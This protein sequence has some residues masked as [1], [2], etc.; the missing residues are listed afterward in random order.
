M[1]ERVVLLNDSIQREVNQRDLLRSGFKY[2]YERTAE[3]DSLRYVAER[4]RTEAKHREQRTWL[5]ALLMIVAVLAP[6]AWLRMRYTTR[7]KRA[8]QEA[9]E[10]LVVSERAREATEVRMR[11]ARD[12]HDQLG[13]DLTKLALLSTEAK[14]IAHA[15]RA[16]VA[17]LVNVAVD[18][19]RVA[20]EA[21]RAIL[22]GPS[23]RTTI[24]SPDLPNAFVPIA[25]ACSSGA[26]WPIPSTAGMKDP[27]RHWTL[28]SNATS[29]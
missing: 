2:A 11:I 5:L 13:S 22:S 24:H 25:H 4:T 14:V 21:N 7:A 1:H 12:V 28:P 23:T 18:I 27:T 17:D 29:T 6:A 10:K 26:M 19:E 3:T 20:G 8:L 16:S 15:D 9:Q